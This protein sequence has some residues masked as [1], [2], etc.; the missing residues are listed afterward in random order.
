MILIPPKSP[1]LSCS[2]C[3][4]SISVAVFQEKL[5]GISAEFAKYFGSKD[6]VVCFESFVIQ[7]YNELCHKNYQLDDT[8]GHFPLAPLITTIVQYL[9]SDNVMDVYN[10][11][12]KIQ[13]P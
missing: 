1:M 9:P 12:S 11:S 13:N 4:S 3:I 10:A 7:I 8:W 2:F 6:K 5:G